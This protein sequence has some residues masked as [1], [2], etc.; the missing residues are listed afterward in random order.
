MPTFAVLKSTV[1]HT[2]AITLITECKKS[3]EK[4]I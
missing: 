1:E 2:R 4:N 3:Q